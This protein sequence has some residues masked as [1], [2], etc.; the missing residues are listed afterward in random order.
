MAIQPV[1]AL[2]E[3]F[4]IIKKDLGYY[5]LR[6]LATYGLM[7]LFSFIIISITGFM[8]TIL[9]ISTGITLENLE[10]VSIVNKQDKDTIE[11]DDLQ[12][13]WVNIQPP[14]DINIYEDD[15][16]LQGNRTVDK[17]SNSLDFTGTGKFRAESQING[18]NIFLR[19]DDDIQQLGVYGFTGFTEDPI[20]N[21]NSSKSD[22][23]DFIHKR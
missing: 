22:E 21:I 9:I 1:E 4:H 7:T 20:N 2:V 10:D 6:T 14:N 13:R 19:M 5:L 17:S 16:I 11:W 12:Q 15:G 8:F 3:P 23:Y 18:K